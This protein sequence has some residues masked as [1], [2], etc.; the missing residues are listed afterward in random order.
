MPSHGKQTD[1][2]DQGL[3]RRRS[4]GRGV[5][6]RLAP[7][8]VAALTTLLVVLA[9]YGVMVAEAACPSLTLPETYG[10]ENP[11]APSMR[12][13]CPEDQVNCATGNLALEQTDLA[14][15]GRGPGLRLTR[16]F[17]SK[18]A[19]QQKTTKE[20]G[21]LGFGWTGSY[22]AHLVVG[23]ETATVVHDNGS[24]VPF[25]TKGSEYTPPTWAQ[26]KLSKVGA[27][28]IY[29]L[30]D[31]SK[32]KVQ[33]RRAPQRRGRPQRQHAHHDVQSRQPA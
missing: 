13:P 22:S 29:T 1:P 30:P 5:P 2:S 11:A 15:G 16:S 24:E 14:V 10:S 8:S 21:A 12:R 23:A 7:T 17:N 19:A 27:N 28:Y 26:V 9:V 6:A 18:L 4:W 20:A 3:W 31:Q 32:L 25:T 33:Q